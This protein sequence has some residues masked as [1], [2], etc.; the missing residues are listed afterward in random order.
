MLTATTPALKVL[1]V[2]DDSIL[3]DLLQAILVQH[4]YAV[5]TA[6]DGLDALEHIRACP[7]SV[8]LTDGQIPGLTGFQL[9]ERI[10]ALG[11]TIPVVLLSG[12]AAGVDAAQRKH[13]AAC[14]GKPCPV[15]ELLQ[16][17]RHVVPALRA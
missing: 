16:T 9:A 13:L 17:L 2:E 11:L 12:D 5:T 4:G 15:D 1:L 14:L 7:P 6:A 8:V 3:R 10:A